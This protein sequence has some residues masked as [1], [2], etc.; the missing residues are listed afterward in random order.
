MCFK[1]FVSMIKVNTKINLSAV[2]LPSK[3]GKNILFSEIIK[4]PAVVYFYPK[5]M[6]PGCTEEACNFR[7]VNDDI[8]KLGYHV[9]GISSDSLSSHEKFAKKYGLNF[10]LISDPN[11]ELQ[12]LFGVWVEKTMYGKK[13]MGTLRSTFIINADGVVV[14]TWGEEES[15]E[16]K[17]VTKTHGQDVLNFLTR[18]S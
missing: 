6:T 12:N 1:E 11:H 18:Q 3:Q 9:Y 13:Y 8:K 10:E 7:D 15:S 5:D 4:L 17:V 2:S 14:A 16:G